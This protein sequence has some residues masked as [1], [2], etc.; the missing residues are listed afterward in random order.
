VAGWVRFHAPALLIDT[1]LVL[2]VAALVRCALVSPYIADRGFRQAVWLTTAFAAVQVAAIYGTSYINGAQG[3]FL[4]PAIGP[5]AA[6][7]AVGLLRWRSAEARAVVPAGAIA[8][9]LALD[10]TSWITTVIPAYALHR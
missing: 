7:A 1:A 5:F 10:I 2:F 9:L 3:R 4:F 6:L 8:I